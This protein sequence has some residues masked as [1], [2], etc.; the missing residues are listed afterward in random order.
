MARLRG[1]V[2][3]AEAPS[4]RLNAPAQDKIKATVEAMRSAGA[5]EAD[6]EAFIKG[7]AA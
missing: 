7:H 1:E 4:V 3:N 5:P 6:I 2:E